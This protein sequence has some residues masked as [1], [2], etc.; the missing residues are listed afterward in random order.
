MQNEQTKNMST[1]ASMMMIIGGRYLTFNTLFGNRL[2]WILGGPLGI[3]GYL[4]FSLNAP[5]DVSALTGAT[6]E[7]F[8]GIFV[9]FNARN[10]M[11][12]K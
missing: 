10:R 4:L 9:Y 2:F 11:K 8:F 5:S 12:T 6:I 3:A 1:T 7:I